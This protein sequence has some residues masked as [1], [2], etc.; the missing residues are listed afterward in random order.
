FRIV[1]VN[2]AFLALSGSRR[3]DVIGI[4]RLTRLA[5][6]EQE[7]NVLALH[8]RALAGEHVTFESVGKHI[9]GR[10]FMLEVR[11]VPMMHQGRPHVLY[12]S[13]DVTERRTAEAR[14]RASE[15]QY[16]AI[17]NA[18]ADAM[19]IWDRDYR[20]VD[21]NPAFERIY[22][23]TREEVVGRGFEIFSL[24]E[25]HVAPFQ[26]RGEPHALAIGRDVTERKAAEEH[27]RASEE[28]YRSI[29]NASADSL[30]LRDAD[31]T[32]VDVNL[33]YEAMSGRPREEA[34]GRND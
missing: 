18:S 7:Q 11:G 34:L 21:V 10:T 22:G 27:L 31:F 16:R 1:D 13:R 24:A 29:F 6:P 33:A 3:E 14:L 4:A 8:N 20:R 23:W 17:F 12:V 32:V 19:I 2:P 25:S 15:E 26:H 28:Q 9:A 5:Q 30:V